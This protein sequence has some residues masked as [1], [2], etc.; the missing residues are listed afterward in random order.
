MLFR[1]YVAVQFTYDGNAYVQQVTF[2]VNVA[3]FT[4]TVNANNKELSSKYTELTNKQTQTD[5]DVA[6]LQ[7]TINGVPIK[8]NDDLTK[9]TSEIKQT[10]REISVE[11]SSEAVRSGRNMLL[12]SDFHRQGYGYAPNG[13]AFT[14]S[15]LKIRTYDGFAGCNSLFIEQTA[16][17]N[18]YAGVRWADVPV[19][20]GRASCRERV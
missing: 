6:N 8:S 10:A 19:K 7:T 11:V 17:G 20:I 9:Y 18:S 1:S 13:T 14:E 3:K 15:A 4:G 12:G 5:K 16:I 2:L